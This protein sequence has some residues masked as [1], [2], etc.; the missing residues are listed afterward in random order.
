MQS[1]TQSYTK[2]QI[3]GYIYHFSALYNVDPKVALSTALAENPTLDPNARGDPYGNG[4]YHSIGIFQLHDGGYAGFLGD[5][6]YDPVENIKAG[7]QHL[8]AT[9]NPGN[10]AL[11][12]VISQAPQEDLRQLW[13]SN[14][15]RYYNQL[16][17]ISTPE[18]AANRLFGA[19]A[20]D[21]V[22]GGT[23][24]GVG[25][26]PPSTGDSSGTSVNLASTL[27][28]FNSPFGNLDLP[29]ARLA[30]GVVTLI[31][32]IFIIAGILKVTGGD[33]V[34]RVASKF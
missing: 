30:Q 23:S 6:R 2:E 25:T 24:G 19:G 22:Q 17:G 3:I 15:N 31:G 29:T 28:L 11:W 13:M 1:T 21:V 10:P 20:G 16:G 8:A 7:V 4:K 12:A 32:V 26:P 9:P 34:M 33:T 5:R 14:F 18:S 27:H